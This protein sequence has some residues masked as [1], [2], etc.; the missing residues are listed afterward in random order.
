MGPIKVLV[1]DGDG[2]S[3]EG[4]RLL[5]EDDLHTVAEARDSTQAMELVATFE[6]QVILVDVHL[7]ECGGL[8]VVRQIKARWPQIK[9]IVL[10]VF[11]RYLDEALAAGA[12]GYLLKGGTLDE[13][14][15]AIR[16]V[17]G[18]RG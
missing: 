4:I 17:V 5:L 2:A 13:L 15:A 18:E 9:L 1:A 12:D 3:R 7:P 6:P 11:D 14:R 10:T 16:R 8:E